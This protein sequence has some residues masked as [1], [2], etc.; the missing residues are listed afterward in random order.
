MDKNNTK[1]NLKYFIPL[2]SGLF[3]LLFFVVLLFVIAGR[4]TYWQGLGYA[5][6]NMAFLIVMLIMS[7]NRKEFSELL[8]ERLN[9]RN[10][11]KWWDRLFWMLYRPVYLA[12]IVI[13]G[14]DAGRFG[15]TAE[16]HPSLY[17]VGYIGYIISHSLV[18]WAMWENRFFSNSTRIQID[19]G[20]EVVHEG[21]YLFVRHPGYLG[22]ILLLISTAFVL[23]SLWA[24]VPVG[25]NIMLLIFRT[26]LEDYTLQKHLA[27]YS[28]YCREVRYHLLPR[29]W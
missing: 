11:T 7:I 5:L 29:L 23:G 22:G 10:Q 4:V 14:L 20:H 3:R 26:Y 21:P 16:F 18:L 19:K 6:I 17:I 12:I 15:W 13:A 24:L 8:E 9:L 27:G 2:L 1:I 25:I 28:D